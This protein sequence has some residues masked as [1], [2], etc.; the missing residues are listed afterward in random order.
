LQV[1]IFSDS[2][3]ITFLSPEIVA[4]DKQV[5]FSSSRFMISELLLGMV[6]LVCACW[7]HN[8]VTLFPWL[9]STILVRGHASVQCQI[10]PLFPCFIIIITFMQSI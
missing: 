4:T 9:V 2:F 8:M 7:Y 6:L 5:H 3:L 10:L 1:R